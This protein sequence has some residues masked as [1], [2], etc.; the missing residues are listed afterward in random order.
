MAAFEQVDAG[1]VLS[2]HSRETKSLLYVLTHSKLE[3]HIYFLP[4]VKDHEMNR[5]G[6]IARYRLQMVVNYTPRKAEDA[7]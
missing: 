3:D 7:M 2:W 6:Y 4:R 5:V 1:R